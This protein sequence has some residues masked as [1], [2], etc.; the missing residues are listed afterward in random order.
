MAEQPFRYAR[1]SVRASGFATSV[2]SLTRIVIDLYRSIIGLGSS[3][4]CLNSTMKLVRVSFPSDSLHA[5][6]ENLSK[7]PHPSDTT[8]PLVHY[9]HTFLERLVSLER[10]TRNGVHRFCSCVF[11]FQ[12]NMAYNVWVCGFQ[13]Y[14]VLC[15]SRLCWHWMVRG[16][17]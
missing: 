8:C 6:D 10:H 2:D 16:Q 15:P 14:G 12:Y 5:T 11:T 4:L 13:E 3:R 7:Y 9:I 1:L 17:L